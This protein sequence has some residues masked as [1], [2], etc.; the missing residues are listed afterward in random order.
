MEENIQISFRLLLIG[1]TT[2]CSILLLVVLSSKLLIK[3]LNKYHSEPGIKSST[4]DKKVLAAINTTVE[5]ITKGTGKV[6]SI[7]KI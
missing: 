5:I 7:K 3:I 1:M 4:A 6:E 2:V